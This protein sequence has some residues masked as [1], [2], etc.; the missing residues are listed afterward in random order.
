VGRDWEELASRRVRW[1]DLTSTDWL[2]R[3]EQQLVPE[4]KMPGSLQ[5]FET[6]LFRQDGSSVPVLIGAAT[7]EEGGYQGVAF[8][9]DLTERKRAADA[10]RALQTELAHA[11][12]LATLGQLV[13]SI[14]HE[15]NQPIGAVR[16]NAHAALRFLA[17]DPPDLAEVTEALECM[18]NETYR[19][20]DIISGIRDQ[21]R[22]APPR[23]EYVDLNDAIEE[24]IAIVRG[25]L[26]KHR[27]S[28]QMLLADRVPPVYG[29]R[30]Q[31]QQV[32]LNLILN[33]I[34]AMTSVD[35]D[36]RELVI[37]TRSSLAEGVLVEVNDSGPGVAAGDRERIFESFYTTK[38]GGLGIGLSICRSVIDA[39]AG[40]LW[41]EARQP[42]GAGFRLTLPAGT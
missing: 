19:V 37:R 6:E 24:V 39:H 36:A 21:V 18:V 8:V 38:G 32:M 34:E 33:A 31:L 13:A 23:K 12:R 28:V 35:D 11:N 20:G 1:M 41:V 4:P 26:S 40:R 27:V 7:F 17:G 2:G 14:A 22:K 15:V 9:L 16:N 30:V 25:E 29:D 3:D 10:L 42:R 5:P